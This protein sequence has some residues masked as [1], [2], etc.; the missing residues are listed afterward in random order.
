[1]PASP[2]DIA[3]YTSDGVVVTVPA[4]PDVANAILAVFPDA[5]RGDEEESFFIDP[6][7]AQAMLQE[8]FFYLSDPAPIHEAVQ[9]EENIGIGIAI[10]VV[11]QVPS[12]RVIDESRGI[13]R[14]VRVAG[15]QVD[16]ATDRYSI[17]VLS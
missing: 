13:D 7:H 12:V 4:D 8:R 17:E 9:V 1:M 16:R 6:G 5:K 11:P 2:S 15:Y 3:K 10:G 14:I